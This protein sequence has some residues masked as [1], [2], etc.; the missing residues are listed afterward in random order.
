MK[1]ISLIFLFLLTM[2]QVIDAQSD[3]L[4][5]WPGKVPNETEPKSST[6]IDIHPNGETRVIKVT[7]P[8]LAVFLPQPDKKNHKGIIVCPGG[9]YTH[10]AVHKEGF[11]TAEWLT[12]LGFTV[13]VLE[14]R[15]PDNKAGALQDI[16]RAFRLVRF[17]SGKYGID[18]GKIG[19]I[20]FSAGAD[21][22]A[23]AGLTD[24]DKTILHRMLQTHSPA[25]P[26]V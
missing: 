5:L 11:T 15:V 14:Y 23:R 8:F 16:Q 24:P 17:L 19:G 10:L 3:T 26:A 2:G 7:N 25:G 13:F 6:V 21:L 1:R 22:V 18:P 20:G 4:Y 12:K 9:A